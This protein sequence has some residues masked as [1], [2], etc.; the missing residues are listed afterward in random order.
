MIQQNKVIRQK[1][2]DTTTK[3]SD[4][5]TKR[6]I[7]TP[8]ESNYHSSIHKKYMTTI[9]ILIVVIIFILIGILIFCLKIKKVEITE[10][11][12]GHNIINNELYESIDTTSNV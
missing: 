5:T 9:I 6:S 4:T 8:T 1:Q 12:K 11:V 10:E 2:S 3:R 7:T